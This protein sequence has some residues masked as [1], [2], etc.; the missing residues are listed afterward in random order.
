MNY[1]SLGF[2]ATFGFLAE[3]FFF[4]LVEVLVAVVDVIVARWFGGAVGELLVL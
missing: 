2:V 1:F 3:E 4:V